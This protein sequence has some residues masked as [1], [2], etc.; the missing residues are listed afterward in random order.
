MELLEANQYV[1][2]L[3][4]SHLADIQTRNPQF[5]LRSFAKKVGVSASTLSQALHGKR[6]MNKSTVK[7]VLT[8]IAPQDAKAWDCLEA[9]KDFYPATKTLPQE[10]LSQRI[11][12]DELMFF[13]KWYHLAMVTFFDSAH[14]D[15]SVQ[16]IADYFGISFTEAQEA[17]DR[18]KRLGIVQEHQERLRNT[19]QFYFTDRSRLAESIHTSKTEAL[20]N[21]VQVL[22]SN[23]AKDTSDFSMMFTVFDPSL[24]P[25]A[26]EYI[27]KMKKGFA[28]R[29]KGKG[30]K[31]AVY[32]LS[33][34]LMP[35]GGT[36]AKLNTLE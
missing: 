23:K 16:S 30:D 14:Y 25:E 17:V 13:K 6:V 22:E 5:S 34:Q 11:P 3:I 24:V 2:S 26:I 18:L 35:C 8:E 19:A 9:F 36:P 32:Q 1:L 10:I 29:F 31:S 21:A 27:D 15:G 33:I 28:K 20:K 7:K 12:E 4:K